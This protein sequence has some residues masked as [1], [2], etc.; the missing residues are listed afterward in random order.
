MKKKVY[1]LWCTTLAVGLCFSAN[2]S[3]GQ[4]PADTDTVEVIKEESFT[5][6]T[7][8]LELIE[9]HTSKSKLDQFKFK[10][11]DSVLT[12]TQL[13]AHF[14][15]AGLVQDSVKKIMDALEVQLENQRRLTI[16][17]QIGEAIDAIE[18]TLQEKKANK[19]SAPTEE[20]KAEIDVEIT[21]LG[22][23]LKVLGNNYNT[24]LTGLDTAGFFEKEVEVLSLQEELSDILSPTIRSFKDLTGTTR[25]IAKLTDEIMYYETRIAQIKDGIERMSMVHD[26]IRNP[27][28]QK[29]ADALLDYWQ[30]QEKE[31]TTNLN[32]AQQHLLDEEQILKE[33]PSGFITFAQVQ[34]KNVLLA[35]LAFFGIILAFHL[36]HRLVQKYSPLHRTDKHVFWANLIDLLFRVFAVVIGI[37]AVIYIFFVV[38]DWILLG[39]ILLFALAVIW[40]TKN[41]IGDYVKQVQLLLNL[42]AV[43]QNER[44]I[45]KGVPYKVE[46]IGQFCYLT[47]PEL[48]GGRIRLPIKDL[49]GLRSRNYDENEVWFPT[50]IGDWIKI[51]GAVRQIKDQSPEMVLI[52]NSAGSPEPMQTSAF[53]NQKITNLSKSKFWC[54]ASFLI[55]NKYRDILEEK[56]IP[57]FKARIQ[58]DMNAKGYGEFL[59]GEPYVALWD[60]KDGGMEIY[61]EIGAQPELARRFPV[62]QATLKYSMSA[63]AQ[64]QGWEDPVSAVEVRQASDVIYG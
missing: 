9:Q 24:A 26:D 11:Q 10:I 42:G 48:S 18:Q 36:L 28:A 13:T 40:S 64:E 29:R 6:T 32:T 8:I 38:N 33:K 2:C 34:G 35:M 17:N 41:S 50:S 5:V 27:E 21:G 63:V 43:R 25:R 14:D 44:L 16:V 59:I 22:E 53:L 56:I 4:Q 45:Y 7:D 57:L 62:M 54:G 31:F 46:K 30:Q 49:I 15:Q 52:V 20:A 23:R 61:S 55:S 12:L 60:L 19:D 51:G 39:I 3:F 58:K 37:M 1:Y 47:N